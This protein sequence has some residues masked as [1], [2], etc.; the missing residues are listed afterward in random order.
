MPE[1]LETTHAARTL[2]I[3]NLSKTYPNGVRA[4]DNVSL[5]IPAGMFGLLGPNGAGKS[6]LMRTI[7]TR[8]EPDS[9]GPTR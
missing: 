8:Q 7:A 9:G 2:T 1:S 5:T 6:T 3:E 4:L